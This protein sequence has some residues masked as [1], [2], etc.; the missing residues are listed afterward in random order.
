[1][2]W[3]THRDNGISLS[4]P[5][6]GTDSYRIVFDDNGL[7]VAYVVATGTDNG[8]S[9]AKLIASAPRLANALRLVVEAIRLFRW[10][11]PEPV[12]EAAKECRKALSE[13]SRDA[14][15]PAG[16]SRGPIGII[17]YAI[18]D[19]TGHHKIGKA[20]NFHNRLKQLQTGNGRKLCLVAYLTVNSE[21]TAYSVESAAKQ[22]LSEFQ[23]VGEWFECN[24]H[25]AFQALYEAASSAGVDSVPVSVCVGYEDEEVEEATDG[26]RS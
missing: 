14:L 13:A 16:K 12:L 19:G 18:S 7:D 15:I 4:G 21:H 24:S 17:V 9:N 26:T 22:W 2:N 11:L 8:N 20:V 23:A 25:Y 1:M 6:G 3:K 10:T 5:C